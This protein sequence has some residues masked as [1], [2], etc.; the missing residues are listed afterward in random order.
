MRITPIL[1]GNNFPQSGMIASVTDPSRRF[2][3][4]M[5][6]NDYNLLLKVTKPA[7]MSC[8]TKYVCLVRSMYSYYLQVI[9][10]FTLSLD[11]FAPTGVLTGAAAAAIAATVAAAAAAGAPLGGVIETVQTNVPV[12]GGMT[13]TTMIDTVVGA[14]G[15]MKTREGGIAKEKE[16]GIGMGTGGGKVDR[17][18]TD[19]ATTAEVGLGIGIGIGAGVAAAIGTV[20]VAG[21]GGMTTRFLPEEA[22][23]VL[24]EAG[25]RRGGGGEAHLAGGTRTEVVRR[26]SSAPRPPHNPSYTES[27]TDQ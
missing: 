20:I 5:V 8:C 19:A 22:S 10:I 18:A 2:L 11:L 13:T 4:N 3:T 9:S 12:A 15:G 1:L 24:G 21:D 7:L 6:L 26:S 16:R 27:M 23:A 14:V 25:T 17:G